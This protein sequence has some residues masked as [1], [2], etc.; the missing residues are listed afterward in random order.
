[1][2]NLTSSPTLPHLVAMRPLALLSSI[3]SNK[4]HPIKTVPYI[5]VLNGGVLRHIG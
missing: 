1:M 4:R 5:P 3:S 2:G